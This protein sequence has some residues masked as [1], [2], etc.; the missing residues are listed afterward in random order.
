MLKLT[1]IGHL[2]GI[3][4]SKSKLILDSRKMY[5]LLH[6]FG[7]TGFSFVL[8]DIFLANVDTY[9]PLRHANGSIL[10]L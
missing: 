2:R 9:L 1:D 4:D 10:I 6:K 5:I 8:P 7:V 3:R